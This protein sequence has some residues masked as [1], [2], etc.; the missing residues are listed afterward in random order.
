MEYVQITQAE[1]MPV[2]SDEEKA[3]FLQSLKDADAAIDR[4]E[5]V[6]FKPGEFSK[7]MRERLVFHRSQLRR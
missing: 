1:E 4:G 6:E 5:C 7:W 3:E 2:L